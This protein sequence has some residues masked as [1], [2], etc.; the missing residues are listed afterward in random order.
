M[1]PMDIPVQKRGVTNYPGLYFVG[2]PWLHN[3]KSGLIYAVGDDAA[4]IAGTSPM[5]GKVPAP[6]IV[7]DKPEKSWLSHDFC[8]S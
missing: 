2:L 7:S 4:H 8:C 6:A 3:A 1:T 5:I